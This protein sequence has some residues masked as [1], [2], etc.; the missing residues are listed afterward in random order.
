MDPKDE[1]LEPDIMLEFELMLD[2]DVEL[3]LDEK[4]EL[5]LDIELEDCSE[6]YED[7]LDEDE[8]GGV[9]PLL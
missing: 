2:I 8:Q 4:L 9:N 6:L 7:E 3:E 5:P 1:R